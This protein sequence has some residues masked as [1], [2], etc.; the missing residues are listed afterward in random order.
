[1]KTPTYPSA[2]PAGLVPLLFALL[3][4]LPACRREPAPPEVPKE[5]RSYLQGRLTVDPEVD[6]VPDY[7]GFE[8]LVAAQDSAGNPDTLGFATTDTTGTFRLD[9]TAPERGV[10]PLYISRRGTVLKVGELAVD[11]GD[12]ATVNVV[13]PVEEN[14]LLMVRS[15]ENAA[16][17]AY[18][19]TK[20]QYNN[21]VM[22]MLQGGGY[23]AGLARQNVGQTSAILWSLREQF[24]GT[25]GADIATAESVIMLDG[26]DDSLL[27][28]R[29]QTIDP[30]N[31]SFV[32]VVRAARR[33][34]ARREGQEAALALVRSFEQKVEDVETKAGIASEVVVA[35]SD[36]LRRNEAIEA[37]RA[38]K[39]DYAET[40][41]AAWADRAIYEIEN[42]APGTPA[43]TFQV[44][45]RTGRAVSLEVLRDRLVL[46]EFYRPEDP[47]FDQQ[48][49]TRNALLTALGPDTLV[50]VSI[51]LQPDTSL[52][53]AFR[54][55]RFF[56]GLHVIATQ[57]AE[58]QVVKAYNVSVLPTR[59]L[60]DWRGNLVRK[61]VG[62]TLGLLQDDL[63]ALLRDA[64]PP[65]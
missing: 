20:A 60:I 4:V 51:S 6:P 3:L 49:A 44:I 48:L 53:D 61:Y 64:R 59:V 40:P 32:D 31:P 45:D 26:W 62:N 34:Q 23:Q 30:T 52:N 65:T 13:F 9:V 15:A 54:E 55:G 37:A 11:E 47:A 24:P 12:S 35:Y 1:V 41:W 46:L 2:A 18:K 58:S 16:W 56:P 42:L 33:A 63:V 5:V 29:A 14:R 19:N 36:S 50:V 39:R 27:V 8:V 21:A 25:I 22:R 17:L 38:L 28:A 43:P 10:Y 57:G 7:S